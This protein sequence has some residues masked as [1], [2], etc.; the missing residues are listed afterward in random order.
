MQNNVV[1]ENALEIERQKR[2]T[3]ENHLAMTGVAE[4]PAAVRALSGALNF[5]KVHYLELGNF[6]TE[7]CGTAD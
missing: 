2:V 5:L 6:P 1:E 3:I 4:T 7:S